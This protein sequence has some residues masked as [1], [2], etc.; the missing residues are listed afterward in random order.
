VLGGD[1]D[2]LEHPFENDRRFHAVRDVIALGKCWQDTREYEDAVETLKS[3]QPVRY[4]CTREELDDR[5]RALDGLVRAIRDEGYLTQRELRSRRTREW[6]LG[7]Q[8]EISVAIGRHGDILY[9]DGAHRLAIAKLVGVPRL[10]VEVEVR[11]ADWMA[12]RL[13]IEQYALEHGG[14]VPTPLLHPDLDNVPFRCTRESRL[15]MLREHLPITGTVLDITPGWGYFSTRL[16]GE[17]WDCTAL[18]RP[19]S[20]APF[21]GGLRRACRCTFSL[22]SEDELPRLPGERRSFDTGLLMNDGLDRRTRSTPGDLA[23]I[24]D[25]VTLRQLFVEP[26]AFARSLAESD[27]GTSDEASFLESLMKLTGLRDRTC[28][29]GSREAGPLYRLS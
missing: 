15:R 27:D 14:R 24:L 7:R 28:V 6:Q 20:D 16:Q 12:F 22:L 8:D 21:L 23:R 18:E 13:L 26:D 10:P 4:C 5:F 25:V 17:G 29:G 9:R 3:G 11:H 2:A 1:W 19:P